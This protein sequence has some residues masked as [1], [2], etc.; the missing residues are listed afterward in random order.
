[1]E[2]ESNN[3]PDGQEGGTR[4]P[5]PFGLRADGKREPVKGLCYTHEAVVDA[6]ISMPFVTQRELAAYFGYT[7]SWL[8][9]LIHSDAFQ[10]LYRRRC[11][12]RGELAVHSI[13][14]KLSGLA[15]QVIE[16]VSQK[17]AANV[18]SES[19]IT[20]T[21]ETTLKA[22][23]YLGGGSGSSIP[24][25]PQ[26]HMHVHVDAANLAEARERAAKRFEQLKEAPS[27]T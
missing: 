16:S 23:G 5:A 13:T 21:M 3:G 25:G 17:I 2:P 19:L 20:S 1:M 24:P 14:D 22:L 7:E 11:E 4:T 18:A 10:A 26:Q 15:G 8:S 6:L 9:Q 27:A 12:E